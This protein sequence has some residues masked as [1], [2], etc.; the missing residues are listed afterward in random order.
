M[1]EQLKSQTVDSFY[2]TRE[3]MFDSIIFRQEK[4]IFLEFGVSEGK[5]TEYFF[6]KYNSRIDSY[7][8]FDTF[9]GLPEP[10]GDL[11]AGTF[12]T[13]G[14]T[15]KIDSKRVHWHIGKV[16]DSRELITQITNT[17]HLP[18][19]FIFDLDLYEP[20]K[21]VWL[22]IKKNL[23]PGDI[24]YFDEAYYYDERNL[25]EEILIDMGTSIQILGF[26]IFS[27][28]YEIV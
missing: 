23:N 1:K 22:A 15:P 3:R 17:N 18:K 20:S 13:E 21:S 24:L 28:A 27:T 9:M 14:R 26:T 11:P 5:L 8:G 7:H 19:I 6:H 25:V 10:W 12:S 16:E 4:F 2:L